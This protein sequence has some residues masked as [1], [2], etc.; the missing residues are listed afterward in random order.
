MPNAEELGFWIWE[1][2]LPLV[3]VHSADA[4]RLEIKIIQR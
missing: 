3:C 1:L 4:V 2:Y